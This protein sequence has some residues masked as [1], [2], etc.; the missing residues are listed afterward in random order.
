M[1]RLNKK[2]GYVIMSFRLIWLEVRERGL[3]WVR[4]PER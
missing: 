4:C 2:D 3:Q 1:S